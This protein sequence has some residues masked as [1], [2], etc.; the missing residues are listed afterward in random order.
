V[1]LLIWYGLW[2]YVVVAPIGTIGASA[3][4]RGEL[5]PLV[6]ISLGAAACPVLVVAVGLALGKGDA[7]YIATFIRGTI[8]SNG[9]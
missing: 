9:A 7:D 1:F 3:V 5:M 8:G 6:L 2:A 4:E